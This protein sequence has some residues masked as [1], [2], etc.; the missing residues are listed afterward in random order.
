M[1]FSF[2]KRCFNTKYWSTPT[3]G[4]VRRTIQRRIAG[5]KIEIKILKLLLLAL[6]RG[7]RKGV[8]LL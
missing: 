6:R 4:S 5:I 7:M 8:L 3:Y 2:G 1:N